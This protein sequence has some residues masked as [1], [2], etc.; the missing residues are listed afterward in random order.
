MISGIIGNLIANLIWAPL[1]W[2]AVRELRR[3]RTAVEKNHARTHE[4]V[5]SL[6]EQVASLTP[7]ED[8]TQL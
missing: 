1:V 5:Q 7:P 4:L 3:Y 6:T 8:Q 2:L